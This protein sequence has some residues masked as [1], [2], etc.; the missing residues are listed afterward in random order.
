MTSSIET[1]SL[2]RW[3]KLCRRLGLSAD[4][5]AYDA[6]I[7]AHAEK[8]RAYH[9]LDHIAACFRHLDDVRDQL[10]RP[11]EVEIALWFHD[12]IYKPLSRSNEEDSAKWAK[13]FLISANANVTL[14]KEV[15][16]LVM[17]T[18]HNCQRHSGDAAVLVDI[19]LSILGSSDQA[20]DQFEQNIRKEYRYVP[21][22]IYSKKRA[23]LLSGFLSHDSIYL[24]DRFRDKY[25]EQA[26]INIRRTV[27]RLL[28]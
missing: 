10:E 24:N 28:S 8:Q 1:C 26:K 11:D 17:A 2:E 19:D 15:S 4:G 22:F 12:A 16:D 25:E 21:N 7:K 20:Y 13:D 23:E 9:T 18:K 14:I 27:E 6:L 3:N 5:A